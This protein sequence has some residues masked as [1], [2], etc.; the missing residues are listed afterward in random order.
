MAERAGAGNN[1]TRDET[2]VAYD[3]FVR[4]GES[5][6]SHEID[7]VA[8]LIGRT[9]GAV[10]R[11]LGNLLA[12]QSAGRTGLPHRSAIDDDVVRDFASD[13]R[14]LTELARR[15]TREFSGQ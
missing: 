2:I 14:A 3:L 12:A 11:K 10:R 15:L 7:D 13:R 1:W 8:E 4:S 5:P 9:P 6:K